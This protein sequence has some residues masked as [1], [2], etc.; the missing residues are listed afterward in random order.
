MMYRGLKVT[1]IPPRY[2]SCRRMARNS[3]KTR[4]QIRKTL[5]GHDLVRSGGW[6]SLSRYGEREPP[7]G[8]QL[9]KTPHVSLSI[10]GETFEGTAHF[11]RQ[12]YCCKQA[13]L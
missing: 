7:V 3:V 9:K 4:S 13:S 11:L 12:S 6:Q 8:A 2:F 5:R 10:G 1:P